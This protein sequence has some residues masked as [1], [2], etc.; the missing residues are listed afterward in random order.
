MKVSDYPMFSVFISKDIMENMD[1]DRFMNYNKKKEVFKLAFEIARKRITHMGFPSM[2][3][4]VVFRHTPD[5]YGLAHGGPDASRTYRRK[6]KSISLNQKFIDY[7]SNPTEENLRYSFGTLV[8]TIV[9]EWAHIW[10]FN[11][12]KAFRDAIK[13]YHEALTHSNIDKISSN[14]VN[15]E[16]PRRVFKRFYN[17]LYKTIVDD[18]MKKQSIELKEIQIDVRNILIHNLNDFG[19]YALTINLEVIKKYSDVIAGIVYNN[20]QTPNKIPTQVENLNLEK[21]FG[22]IIEQETQSSVMKR[23]DVRKQLSDMVRFTGSY[24]LTNPDEAWATAIQKFN[25]L[26]PYHRKRIL[27]LMQVRGPRETPNKRMQKHKKIKRSKDVVDEYMRRF[28][29][30]D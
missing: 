11:N 27:E 7:I 15:S 25:V 13:D 22:D 16:T 9:H 3:V 12:G 21:V 18:Y 17:V 28:N 26:H 29:A 6:S 19:K 14:Y 30:E 23:E 4:N 1:R 8:D 20:L 2:H 5:A 10:M 24:G